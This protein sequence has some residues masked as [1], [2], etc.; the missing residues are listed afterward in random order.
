M[1]RSCLSVRPSILLHILPAH[2]G[3]SL[4]DFSTLKME[5]IRFPETSVHTTTTRRHIPEDGNLHS[6]RRENLKSYNWIYVHIV[7]VY[8]PLYTITLKLLKSG[9]FLQNASL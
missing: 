8:P 6:H 9:D 1:G 5:A 7:P 4:A 3:S 2:P